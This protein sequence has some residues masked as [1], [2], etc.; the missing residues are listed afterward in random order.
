MSW[1]VF[2]RR[3]FQS[4]C[5][6]GGK[7][8]QMSSDL[9]FHRTDNT[10]RICKL[11]LCSPGFFPIV[12]TCFSFTIIPMH[13]NKPRCKENISCI[14]WK[15]TSCVLYRKFG[16][17]ASCKHF[18][19]VLFSHW[20]GAYFNHQSTCWYDLINKSDFRF[21]GSRVILT[22]LPF[23]V[24]SCCWKIR[25]WMRRLSQA[26]RTALTLHRQHCPALRACHPELLPQPPIHNPAEQ[27]QVL[28]YSV[29]D[30]KKKKRHKSVYYEA[31]RLHFLTSAFDKTLG[32]RRWAC[33]LWQHYMPQKLPS[34]SNTTVLSA[35]LKPTL[36]WLWT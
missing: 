10:H 31:S 18:C 22:G 30:K 34:Y 4:M 19:H 16:V 2:K 15:I 21:C 7:A 14:F 6:S 26:L 25:R 20:T 1:Q 29:D 9:S 23:T 35:L 11:L 3:L 27:T 17:E 12:L 5:S 33:K 13:Q 8:G 28:N 32:R 36:K 24:L